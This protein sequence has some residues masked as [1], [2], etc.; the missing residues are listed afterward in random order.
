MLNGPTGVRSIF[1]NAILTATSVPG[2]PEVTSMRPMA[3][4]RCSAMEPCCAT[5]QSYTCVKTHGTC[6]FLSSCINV[7]SMARCDAA[8]RAAE[9]R[10]RQTR[11]GCSASCT[12]A[13]YS[14]S[15]AAVPAISDLQAPQTL[16]RRPT[17]RVSCRRAAPSGRTRRRRPLLGTRC[18]S[19]AGCIPSS[20]LLGRSDR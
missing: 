18:T 9:R 19:S 16:G 11:E 17:P 8:D 12:A 14:T 5:I 1:Q 7:H 6:Y 15:W 3:H 2:A 13:A 20:P 4:A 10:R